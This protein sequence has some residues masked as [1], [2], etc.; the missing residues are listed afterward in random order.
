[1]NINSPHARKNSGQQPTN[2]VTTISQNYN[3]ALA[4]YTASLGSNKN[5]ATNSANKSAASNSGNKNFS[6]NSSSKNTPDKGNPKLKL[7]IPP[8]G[9]LTTEPLKVAEDVT[10]STST[11][12]LAEKTKDDNLQRLADTRNKV[13]Q[14]YGSIL[15]DLKVN[16]QET[17]TQLFFV[18]SGG[19]MVDYPAWKMRPTSHLVSYL[20]SQ[21][22]D[23][24]K[25]VFPTVTSSIPSKS[26]TSARKSSISEKS[27]KQEP[28][29]GNVVMEQYGFV[30]GSHFSHD[31]K[32]KNSKHSDSKMSLHSN[33]HNKSSLNI[34][35]TNIQ[36]P[37]AS[38]TTVSDIAGQVRHESETLHRISELRKNGLWSA[39]RLPKVY[40]LPRKKSHSDFLLEEMQW[41]AADFSQEKKWK[42]NMAKKVFQYFL[43]IN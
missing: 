12:A 18:Q 29:E 14:H 11:A 20:T 38:S 13:L 28:I 23:D 41:L 30:Q 22:L 27:I 9:I 8:T 39:S 1:M 40:E 33:I 34:Q 37:P 6:A 2:N 35:S 31:T 4:N 5:A 15:E 19:N 16:F 26:E 43:C 21:R 17:L 24:S 7:T 32:D 36:K 25:L 3:I 10:V 42:R